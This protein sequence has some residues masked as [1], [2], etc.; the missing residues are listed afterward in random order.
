MVEISNTVRNKRL[1]ETLAYKE[2]PYRDLASEVLEM[3]D[4]PGM[5]NAYS[6]LIDL[7][8]HRANLHLQKTKFTQYTRT[9][10]TVPE[11][12]AHIAHAAHE[13]V[14]ILEDRT[15]AI[16]TSGIVVYNEPNAPEGDPIVA[17]RTSEVLTMWGAKQEYGQKNEYDT[18]IEG[19]NLRVQDYK[20]AVT[21]FAV[22][23]T[24]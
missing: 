6:V 13:Y 10:R 2:K 23:A 4:K 19:V 24:S 21:V 8:E 11:N 5:L 12:Q 3:T 20:G 22:N 9:P 15:A 1:A 16:P 7:A 18:R 14:H 17:N